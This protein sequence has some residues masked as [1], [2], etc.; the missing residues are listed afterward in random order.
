MARPYAEARLA[1]LAAGTA[2]VMALVGLVGWL[3]G[4]RVLYA[5]VPGGGEMMLDSTIALTLLALAVV[6]RV[7]SL[8][9]TCLAG[10]AA[11]SLLSFLEY[12][13]VPPD[14]HPGT[15]G[16]MP[17]ATSVCVLLLTLAALMPQRPLVRQLLTLAAS[18]IGGLVLIGFSY[19]TRTL[20]K[21]SDS[22]MSV[23]AG[24]AVVL[25]A[26]AVL[27]LTED[28]WLRWVW[29]GSDAG[30][31]ALRRTM[32]PVVL[33]LPV[34][35]FLHM[36]GEKVFWQDERVAEAGFVMVLT[37]L[38]STLLF[39]VASSLRL[40][41]LQREQARRDLQALNE[42][43]MTDVRSS[44]DSLRSAQ[45]RIGNLENSQRAVLTVHDN[46]L[47]TLFASG[48]MLRTTLDTIPAEIPAEGSVQRT[49]DCM[50]EAIRAIRVVVEDLN[51]QLGG[52][53]TPAT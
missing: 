20:T 45:Q 52:S 15:P 17:L 50:D 35:T 33:G 11:L 21:F 25:I 39:R 32:P 10:A 42:R 34:L 51:D 2:G 43:L 26:V 13:G 24:L 4:V 19:G 53:S 16:R 23:P 9:L 27:A 22:S 38:F 3:T 8:L 30:A 12:A 48:L 5:P 29:H 14:L 31:V 1:L 6:A 18:A 41:D 44:Y 37:V 7:R 46:V 28:G 36:Q 49:I 47:Q 40:L